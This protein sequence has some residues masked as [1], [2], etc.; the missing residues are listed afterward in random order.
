VRSRALEAPRSIGS[1]RRATA[2]R[3]GARLRKQR[4]P[5]RAAPGSRPSPPRS[6]ASARPEWRSLRNRRHLRGRLRREVRRTFERTTHFS[7][8][9]HP[10][11]APGHRLFGL[12]PERPASVALHG[13]SLASDRPVRARGGFLFRLRAHTGFPLTPSFGSLRSGPHERCRSSTNQ[14]AFRRPFE[15]DE[16]KPERTTSAT[17]AKVEHTRERHVTPPAGVSAPAA[18]IEGCGL[19]STGYPA[20]SRAP[21]LRAARIRPSFGIDAREACSKPEAGTHVGRRGAPKNPERFRL[22]PCPEARPSTYRANGKAVETN[23]ST[24]APSETTARHRG[25]SPAPSEPD[26]GVLFSRARR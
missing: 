24:F 18:A 15:P 8:N 10:S 13:A 5:R 21:A 3:V 19:Q 2:A 7:K 9:E 12:S 22:A 26:E 4:E 11:F 23:P 1:E 25:P 6:V 20:G 16:S 17:D 14:S